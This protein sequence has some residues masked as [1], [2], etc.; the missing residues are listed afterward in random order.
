MDLVSAERI[1]CIRLIK[2][3]FTYSAFGRNVDRAGTKANRG[4]FISVPS[5][6]L[7]IPQKLPE[8]FS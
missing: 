3:T 1:S 6:T 2:D 4:T 7:M 5:E 8:F